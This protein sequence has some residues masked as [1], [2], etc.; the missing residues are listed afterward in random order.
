MYK[1]GNSLGYRTQG[2]R[3]CSLRL[4]S[5]CFFFVTFDTF[6]DLQGSVVDFGRILQHQ[7]GHPE[8]DDRSAQVLGRGMFVHH[9]QLVMQHGLTRLSQLT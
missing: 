5:E 1:Q 6:Q 2:T 4:C 9:C 8:C 3:L 7:G